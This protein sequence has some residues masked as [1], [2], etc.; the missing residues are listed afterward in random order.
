MFIASNPV[1][2]LRTGR[3]LSGKRTWYIGAV[4]L[5][6]GPSAS[7]QSI[8][9]QQ[10]QFFQT[11][12][13]SYSEIFANQAQ[14]RNALFNQ[15]SGVLAGGPGQFGY[16]PQQQASMETTAANQSAGAFQNSQ[17]ALAQKFASQG[18]G[19]AAPSGTVAQAEATLA[20]GGAAEQAQV[21]NQITQQGYAL[22]NQNFLNAEQGTLGLISQ[23]NPTG[24][25]SAATGAGSAAFSSANTINQQK[26]AGSFGA[27]AGGILGDVAG[28]FIGDPMLGNQVV[29]ASM[30]SP[31]GGGGGGAASGSGG[32]FSYTA[33]GVM[34]WLRGGGGS[35]NYSDMMSYPETPSFVPPSGVDNTF[36]V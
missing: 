32:G 24:Y 28:S 8:A 9:G 17:Q 21:Q 5:C 15:Y 10:A 36:P 12:Q 4:A 22:G 14:F 35:P 7:E 6:K 18:G 20:A 31:S 27:I 30:G 33:G 2:S 3:R 1:F 13:Q 11:L 29:G 34:G 26:E 25:A 16:T 23:T 19:A